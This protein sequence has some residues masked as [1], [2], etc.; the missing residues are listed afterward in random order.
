MKIVFDLCLIFIR[1][2]CMFIAVVGSRDLNLLGF[3]KEFSEGDFIQQGLPYIVG[4]LDF[5]R[6]DCA[7]NEELPV[8]VP[9]YIANRLLEVAFFSAFMAAA[10]TANSAFPVFPGVFFFRYYYSTAAVIC[11]FMSGFCLLPTCRSFMVIR[12]KLSE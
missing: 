5:S 10:I 12:I 6:R 2:A 8:F 9:A 7:V 11:F 4:N 3:L 1:V